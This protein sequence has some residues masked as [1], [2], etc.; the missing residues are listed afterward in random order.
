MEPARFRPGERLARESL[1][2]STLH[3]DVVGQGQ[4]HDWPSQVLSLFGEAV[5]R[6][7]G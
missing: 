7:L 3:F 4:D 1:M 5:N 6:E 2:P